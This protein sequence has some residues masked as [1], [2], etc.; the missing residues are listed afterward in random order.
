MKHKDIMTKIISLLSIFNMD[1]E[2][3]KGGGT[4][5]EK[6]RG[7]QR[8]EKREKRRRVKKNS[9]IEEI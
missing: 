4:E 1:I 6:I 2:I 3:E 8:G 5:R 7:E 9:N